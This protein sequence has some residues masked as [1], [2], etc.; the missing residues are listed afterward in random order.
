MIKIMMIKITKI[1]P[2]SLHKIFSPISNQSNLD[3]KIQMHPLL[4]KPFI[5][6][7][8]LKNKKVVKSNL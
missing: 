7:I 4:T 2:I 3:I 5:A 1:Q 8:H 6:Y